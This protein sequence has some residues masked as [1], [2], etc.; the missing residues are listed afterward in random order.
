MSGKEQSIWQSTESKLTYW[1]VLQRKQVEYMPI[2]FACCL[3]NRSGLYF[4]LCKSMGSQQ[5]SVFE[6]GCKLNQCTVSSKKYQCTVIYKCISGWVLWCPI[7]M[8]ISLNSSHRN[9]FA[10]FI[11]KLNQPCLLLLA[12]W[13]PAKVWTLLYFIMHLLF[14]FIIIISVLFGGYNLL[15]WPSG[16]F[17]HYI[18][19]LCMCS[20]FFW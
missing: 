17:V 1:A 16:F 5:Q 12:L 10:S 9:I 19:G 6:F 7:P 15:F 14:V 13:F 2:N 18:L 20:F 4:W 11:L 8:L 3:P